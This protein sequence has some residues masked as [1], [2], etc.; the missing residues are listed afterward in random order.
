MPV[1]DF[2]SYCAILDW[3]RE[4]HY[5][6]PAVNVTSLTTANAVLRGLAE[7]K[8]DG[9]I[10]ISTDGAAFTSGGIALTMQPTTNLVH[11]VYVAQD[12]STFEAQDGILTDVAPTL[13]FLLGLEK[14]AE[15]SGHNLLVPRQ[16]Q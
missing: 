7:S 5:A 2:K 6:L 11:S 12:S 13:L 15:M 14:P 1:A 10:Q 3:V 9:V 4:I 8:V 16:R